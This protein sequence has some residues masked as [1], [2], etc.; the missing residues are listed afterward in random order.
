MSSMRKALVAVVLAA[1]LATFAAAAAQSGSPGFKTAQ[2]PMIDPVAAGVTYQPIISVGDTV[3]DYMFES[4]P[5]GISLAKN[6]KGTV[7]LYVNH[8]TSTVPFPYTFNRTTGTGSGFNDFTNSLVSKLRLHQK[9][10]GVLSGSYAISSD[11]NFQRFCSNFLAT[12]EHGFDRPLLLTNEEGIDW[13]N[14]SGKA[15]PTT[16]GA[17]HARQIGAAVAIDEK[18]G[19]VRAIWGMG[20]HNHENSVAIPGYGHPVVLSG[21]DSF[22]TT[23]PQSQLYSY[24]AGSSDAVWNDQGDLWAFAADGVDDYFDFT[25]GSTVSVT[26]KFVKVPK[27]VATG[28]RPDGTDLMA[29]DKGYPA[30]PSTGWQLDARTGAPLDGPQWVL[31]HWGDTQPQKVFEFVR[32]EDVA[33]DRR[34]P[35]VVY[36]VDSGRGATSAGGNA[37]TSS[38]GRVWKLVLDK[39]DPTKVTSF[40]ILIEGDNAPVKA[41]NEI[42]QPDN[43]ESTGRSLLI[44]EDPGSSQQF[45]PTEVNATTARLWQYDLAS[46]TMRVA[47]RV[48][49]SA[50]EGPL[51]KDQNPNRGLLGAWESSGIVDVSSVFG[52]GAFLID[53]Q[54]GTFVVTEETRR[55]TIFGCVVGFHVSPSANSSSWIFSP[56]RAPMYVISMSRSGSLPE[57]RI[58]LRA[59]STILIG[60]PMARTRIRPRPPIAPA[61][62]TSATASGIVMKN[63]VISPSVTVTGPP[64]SIWRR[65]S[66]ITLPVELSTLPKRTATKRVETSS[67][68]PW[69]PT[70]HSQSVF[71]CP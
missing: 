30:P 16:I 71:V 9:S 21:D 37:F 14:R 67:R 61:W 62:I 8:E 11:A 24:I 39:N 20:R 42:H 31:E 52:P 10:G 43:I 23:P 60:S 28:R 19:E 17:P 26:G 2:G 51:D 38:N 55:A 70:I 54:A 50:D 33:Y 47:A 59:R 48:N 32:V 45:Q 5:D 3:D 53:V 18:S 13:V 58:M 36:V 29:A 64:R 22:V 65:K 34:S 6:G 63:R 56:G 49:Q 69:E 1:G 25:P 4:I 66:G 41:P 44:T 68:S 7:D 27:D 57:R 12:E 40:S 35:N 15:W 46:G